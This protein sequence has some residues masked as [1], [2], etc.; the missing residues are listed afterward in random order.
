[1][2]SNYGCS[3]IVNNSILF[4]NYNIRNEASFIK[5]SNDPLSTEQ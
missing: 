2:Y 4:E 1:M 3:G 5:N